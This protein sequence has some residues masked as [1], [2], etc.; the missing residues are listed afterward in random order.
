MLPAASR[1]VRKRTMAY[2]TCVA[3][4]DS[5]NALSLHG[6]PERDSAHFFRLKKRAVELI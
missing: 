6:K 1:G 2:R 5:V 4:A 3:T